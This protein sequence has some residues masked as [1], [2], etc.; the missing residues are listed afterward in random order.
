[1]K[2]V[3]LFFMKLLIALLA[4]IV[5]MTLILFPQT[6][7][8]AVG[9][10]LISIYTDPFIIYIYLGSIPF[11]IGLYQL[12]VLLDAIEKDKY[13]LEKI[14][15]I[16]KNTKL[17]FSIL[18]IEIAIALL[19]IRFFVKGDDSA[20]PTM[21]GIII[22]LLCLAIVIISSIFQKKALIGDPSG[23]RTRDFRDESP[24]S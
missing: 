11:F 18:I 2:N 4:T 10:D 7:G 8:R 24:T 20:G 12:F 17:V 16:L 19:Y 9:L 1:M 22:A 15:H 13:N 6:E 21:I 5:S 14:M 3:S 23:S